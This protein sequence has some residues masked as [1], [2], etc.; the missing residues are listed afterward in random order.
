MKM[1][2]SLGCVTL[3]C[4]HFNVLLMVNI[5]IQFLKFYIPIPNRNSNSIPLLPYQFLIHLH[6][7]DGS[8]HRILLIQFHVA[9]SSISAQEIF[10]AIAVRYICGE[11]HRS[12]GAHAANAVIEPQIF[13]LIGTEGQI[14]HNCRPTQSE[15]DIYNNASSW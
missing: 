12:H 13:F 6:P 14:S 2:G 15:E 3:S 5:A 9:I 8:R 7:H 4:T 11:C 10:Y 1:C